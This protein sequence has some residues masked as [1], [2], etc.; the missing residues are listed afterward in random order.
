[1]HLM[2]SFNTRSEQHSTEPEKNVP[3]LSFIVLINDD[4][5]KKENVFLIVL[6]K[7]KNK[8]K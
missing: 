2:H 8:K 4:L 7:N 1:M 3:S 6:K 5:M